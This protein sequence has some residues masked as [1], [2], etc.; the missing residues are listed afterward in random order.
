MR[1]AELHMDRDEQRQAEEWEEYLAWYEAERELNELKEK[2]DGKPVHE[3]TR[4]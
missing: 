4:H 1:M 3:V 2:E